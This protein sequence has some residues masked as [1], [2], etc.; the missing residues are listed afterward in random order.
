MKRWSVRTRTALFIMI[1]MPRTKVGPGTYTLLDFLGLF[2]GGITSSIPVVTIGYLTLM[3]VMQAQTRPRKSNLSLLSFTERSIFQVMSMMQKNLK[4]TER[5]KDPRSCSAL[6]SISCNDSLLSLI[7]EGHSPHARPTIYVIHNS[8]A[9]RQCFSPPRARSGITAHRLGPAIKQPDTLVRVGPSSGLCIFA[10]GPAR[11]V[12]P[13]HQPSHIT[14]V[15]R[16]DA[17]CSASATVS[18]ARA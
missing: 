18:R 14:C 1:R 2:S 17:L 15:R 11:P 16:R 3:L 7:A 6:V 8:T 13:A 9:P 4:L 5:C 12:R 10:S